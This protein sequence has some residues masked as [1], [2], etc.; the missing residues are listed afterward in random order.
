MLKE[1]NPLSV[2]SLSKHFGVSEMTLRRDLISLEREGRLRRTRGWAEPVRTEEYEPYYLIRARENRAEK[3]AIGRAAVDMVKDNDVI[4]LDVGTT[5]LEFVRFL[6]R[7]KRVTVL[8]NWLPNVLELAKYPG[9]QV[10][11]LGG[12]L[13][14]AELSLVGSITVEMLREFNAD[15]VFLSI[16]GIS[17]DKG[18]TDYHLDEI[19]V[20]REMLR[21]AKRA[22]VLADHTKIERVAP[23]RVA[24]LGSVHTL[25]TDDGITNQQHETLKNF[26]LD[27]IVAGELEDNG[28]SSRQAGQ[29]V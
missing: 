3:V 10:V 25:V 11:V 24:L 2:A 1:G 15:K 17:V 12:T 23:V 21:T 14:N 7:T 16:G 19:E 18:L 20:K 28:P 8:T 29:G 22:I 27:I 4:L 26:G 13:R 6:G 9:I 5:V